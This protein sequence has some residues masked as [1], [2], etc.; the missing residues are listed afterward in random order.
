MMVKKA[1][2]STLA[3]FL[4]ASIQGVPAR[5][6]MQVLESNVPAFLVGS[7][8]PDLDNMSLPSGGRVKVLILPANETKIFQGPSTAEGKTRDIPFGGTRGAVGPRRN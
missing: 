3:A 7:R 5:A 4:I 6:E 8:I 2:L 1:G